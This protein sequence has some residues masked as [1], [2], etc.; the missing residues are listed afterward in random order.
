MTAPIETILTDPLDEEADA[1]EAPDALAARLRQELDTAEGK[2][3]I[4]G[5]GRV[6]H[7]RLPLRLMERAREEA[8]IHSDED[9]LQAALVHLVMEARPGSR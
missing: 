8:G 7:A 9:L 5:P 2:R 4:A 6:I 1:P 3:L